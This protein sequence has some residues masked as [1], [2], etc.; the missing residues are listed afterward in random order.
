MDR[1]AKNKN[2]KYASLIEGIFLEKYKKGDREVPFQRDDIINHADKLGISV[3]KNVGDVVY[4]F[5]YRAA[6]PTSIRKTAPKGKEWLIVGTGSASYSF[7]L[8]NISRITPNENLEVIPIPD[9]TPEVISMYQLSD[10]QSLLCKIRYNR[11]LD[12]FLGI[13]TYSMQNHLR[14]QIKGLGQIE[15]DE[16]YVGVNK[17]GKH[18]IIPVEAKVGNDMIGTVQTMQDIKCC[19]AKFPDLICVPIAVH[20][21]NEE[22]AL[23]IFRLKLE[24]NVVKI[25]DEKHYKLVSR[26]EMDRNDI[27]GRNKDLADT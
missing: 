10:E 19:E 21:M 2:G 14:T 5:R 11:L 22:N 9:N 3:P 24:E 7:I 17:K 6:L 25:A 27:A 20:K 4:S 12:V 16:I 23:C 15:V 8:G 18:F 26:H 1:K 13:V